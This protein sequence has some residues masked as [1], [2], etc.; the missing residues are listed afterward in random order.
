MIKYIVLLASLFLIA[1]CGGKEEAKTE[2]QKET[3]EQSTEVKSNLEMHEHNAALT[4][5]ADSLYACPMD[6]E[7]VTSDPDA[8][9]VHCGMKLKAADMVKTDKNIQAQAAYT[10][11]MHPEYVTS[12]ATDRCPLCEMR[13]EPVV[14]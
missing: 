13:L 12:E 2:T 1:A 8:P 5:H 6:A 10:C 7:Y 14:N 3:V 11:P 9:C 4:M